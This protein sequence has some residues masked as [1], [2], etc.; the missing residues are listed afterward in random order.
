MFWKNCGEEEEGEQ[1]VQRLEGFASYVVTARMNMQNLVSK[2]SAGVKYKD[3]ICKKLCLKLW[4]E[5]DGYI[6]NITE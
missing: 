4:F 5:S 6:C 2:G 1:W 3:D